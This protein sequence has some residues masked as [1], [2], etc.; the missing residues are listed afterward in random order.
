MATRIIYGVFGGLFLAFG[1]WIGGDIAFVDGHL[2]WP[3]VVS[4][5]FIIVFGGCILAPAVRPDVL[6]IDDAGLHLSRTFGTKHIAWSDVQGFGAARGGKSNART[7]VILRTN[8]KA[9]L[10]H[11]GTAVGMSWANAEKFAAELAAIQREHNE[12]APPARPAS[13]TA[14]GSV[15]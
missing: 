7:V 3:G 2:N 8:K 4:G 13:G 9:G 14:A 6:T 11:I 12:S 5:L 10:G 1:C 15:E